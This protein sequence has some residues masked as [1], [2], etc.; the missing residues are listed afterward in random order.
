MTYENNDFEECI[1]SKYNGT[2]TY[3]RYFHYSQ[4]QLCTLLSDRY[5][6]EFINEMH[7]AIFPSGMCAIDSVFQILMMLNEWGS[8]N[9]VYS[10]ELY[11]DSPRTLKYLNSSYVPINMQKIE[12]DNDTNILDTFRNKIDKSKLTI[13]FLE[14]CSNPNGRVFNFNILSQIREMFTKKSNLYVVIDNTWLTSAI[15]NPFQFN[16]VDIV[17]NSLTKYY[18]AGKSGIMGV[19]IT[20]HQK[21]GHELLEY[22]K[23]KG[24]HTCPL[25]CKSACEN[26]KFMNS[27]IKKT[28]LMTQQLAEYLEKHPKIML[29]NHP[30]LAS[31]SSNIKAKEYFGNL[32][33]SVLTFTVKLKKNDVL[34]WMR[35]SNY[36]CSTSFGS[37][38]SKFDQWPKCKKNS[39]QCRFSV[40]YEDTIEN[41]ISEFDNMLSK[42]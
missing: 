20:K 26:L 23:I 42:I 10:E 30:S 40:G 33:P 24:L 37:A 1:I 17:V 2:F 36:E 41:I 3:N 35:S 7:S 25:Y 6:T 27:R 18:G 34:S 15:F 5:K 22:G 4:R 9:V 21:I 29:V 12:P 8:S 39:S 31:H 28:S 38:S 19:V 16:N 32:Y 14:G 13:L 11:C